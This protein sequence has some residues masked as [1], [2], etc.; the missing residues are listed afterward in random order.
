MDMSEVLTD[1]WATLGPVL[2]DKLHIWVGTQD[3]YY[4]NEGVKAFQD[5]VERLSGSTNY[6]TFTY[7]AGQPHGYT[8]YASTQA[9]LTD[10]ANYITA[11]TPA[12]GQPDPDLSATRGNRGRTCRR[13]VAPR[14]RRRTRRSPAARPSAR[15]SP[16][17][18]ATG[19]P[20][21]RS[22]YQWKRDGAAIDGATGATYTTATAD[23]GH[24]ITVAVTGAKLGYDTTTVRPATRS[25]VT[26]KT[27]SRRRH[28]RRQRAGDA[29]AHA[30]RAGVVRRVHAGRGEGLHG[31]DDGQRD[32]DRGRRGAD[33][34]RSRPP[35]ERHV[36]A[37]AAAAASSSRKSAW[38]APVSNDPVTITFRQHIGATDALR[39]GA[40]SKTL[41]FTLST[42]TP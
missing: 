20:A 41:T 39:T 2:R 12:A 24:A 27:S 21:W 18:R 28:G 4:L 3:T 30:R 37:A 26:P 1:H 9:M 29:V 11:H 7:G 25:R 19:T 42:T 23:V 15:R 5:T 33:R 32:L 36:L 35:D 38:T 13:T 34:V 31:D 14:A 6:A 17:T 40:Y 10:I 22:A 16:P 8:P